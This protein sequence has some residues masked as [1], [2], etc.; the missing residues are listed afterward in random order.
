MFLT[1][2]PI[3]LK[4]IFKRW[5]RDFSKSK[6]ARG[7]KRLAALN[8]FPDCLQIYQSSCRLY[9]VNLSHFLNVQLKDVDGIS[10]S[11]PVAKLYT[12]V[13]SDFLKGNG[14]RHTPLF[15]FYLWV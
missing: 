15:F 12:R 13:H 5:H 6:G 3:K 4:I 2:A 1:T 10:E 7:G 9:G 8:Y 11:S 14:K